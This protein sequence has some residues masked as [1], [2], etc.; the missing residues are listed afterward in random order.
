MK[1][2]FSLFILKYQIIKESKNYFRSKDEA[3][4]LITLC[5]WRL[6]RVTSTWKKRITKYQLLCSISRSKILAAVKNGLKKV[7]AAAYNGVGTVL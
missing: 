1:Q 6:K 3:A 2:L 5:R 4:F 7:Q